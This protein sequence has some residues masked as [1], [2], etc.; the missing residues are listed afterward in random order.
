MHAIDRQ[1]DY[2]SLIYFGTAPG[3]AKKL[4]PLNEPKLVS[5][6]LD[7][8]GQE[9]QIVHPDQILPVEETVALREMIYPLSE[10]ITARKL[11]QLASQALERAPDL[12]E[13]IEPGLKAVRGWA[14]WRQTLAKAH[15]D[16]DDSAARARLAY[17][18][19]FANQLALMLVRVSTRRRRGTALTGDGRLREALR[20]P[21]AP[22]GAQRRTVAEIEGDM[23][24]AT[25]MLRL[26]QGDVG[27][28]KTL[29]ALNAM[30]IAVEAGAQA[31]S[32]TTRCRGCWPESMCGS[33]C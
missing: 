25:P 11:A 31:A 24:Q 32:I 14:G 8:Y 3:Y 16:P 6:K 1:G 15:A 26:L 9:R 5:G 4:L 28:G 21:Y 10:G 33:P 23:A 20:L 18:E 7:L 13:W 27:A 29:V 19:V 17:D 22:T 2:V 30:L 12:P